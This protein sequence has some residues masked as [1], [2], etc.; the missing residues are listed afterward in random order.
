MTKVGT[1]LGSLDRIQNTQLQDI[2]KTISDKGVVGTD[3]GGDGIKAKGYVLA[4]LAWIKSLFSPSVARANIEVKSQFFGALKSEVSGNRKLEAHF[5]NLIDT[6]KGRPL[7]LFDAKMMIGMVDD[8]KRNHPGEFR[9]E[10]SSQP[11][12]PRGTDIDAQS[13]PFALA[14][15]FHPRRVQVSKGDQF[16]N[17]DEE[18]SQNE[19]EG[20]EIAEENRRRREQQLG[21]RQAKFN[22]VEVPIENALTLSG[23]NDLTV[24]TGKTLASDPLGTQ[25]RDTVF[26]SSF[27]TDN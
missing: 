1:F 11:N 25:I 6:A 10:S 3:S 7:K 23:K 19:S 14:S 2:G 24:E 26:K 5:Q 20:E 17:V 16:A 21:L 15:D 8:M 18:L 22:N 9:Q 27:D 12:E 13:D 4:G